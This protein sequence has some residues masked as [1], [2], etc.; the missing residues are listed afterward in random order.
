VPTRALHYRLHDPGGPVRQL[1]FLLSRASPTL[2]IDTTVAHLDDD[3]MV[4]RVLD[5]HGDQAGVEAAAAAFAA[6][7]PPHVVEKEVQART[8]QRL[9]LW[10]KY[11]AQV[12]RGRPSHTA[13]AFRM[14]G[15]D[16]VVTDSTRAGVLTVR[17]LARRAG[18]VA[19]YLKAVRELE[20]GLE[21]LYLG[22]PR[23]EAAAAL[24]PAEEATLRQAAGLGYFEVPGR[25]D[26][27]EVAAAAGLSPSAAS[28]RI[29]RAVGKLVARHLGD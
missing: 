7:D 16:T 3:G 5:V 8:P 19:G 24:T 18:A 2:A 21:L 4:W 15:R 29:R 28:Y 20:P 9:I 22:P 23:D 10:Y 11:R 26:V 17:L 12:A 27:R 1:P 13:L 6:Y 14:L 25:A